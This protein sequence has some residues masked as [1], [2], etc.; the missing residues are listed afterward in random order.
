MR[1]LRKASSLRIFVIASVLG[2]LPVRTSAQDGNL[3]EQLFE[4][5]HS[6]RQGSPQVEGIT[7][8]TKITEDNYQIAEKVLPAEILRVVQAGDM[9]ITVQATSDFPLYEDYIAASLEHFGQAQIGEDGE[10]KN[11]IKGLPFP[12]LDPS[13]PQVGL[14]AA[15]NFRYRYLGSSIQTL[16]TLRS[17]NNSGTVERSVETRYARLYG[18]HR[19]GP[20]SNVPEWEQEGTWWREH[21]I[22]LRP[23]DLEGAQRLTFHHD[24]DTA[25]NGAWVYDPQ[26]RRTRDVVDNHMETSFGLN[27]LVEDHSGFNGYLREHTWRY[28][29][30]QVAL[31]P[32]ILK[33]PQPTLGGKN[34][35]YLTVPW[36]LRKVVIL[37]ATPKNP[38]HPYG[39]R[40]FYIDRQMF[41]VFYAFV[42]DHEGNHWRTLFHCFGDPTFD[43]KNA[44][45]G[46][47][48]HMGNIWVDYKSNHASIWT[49]DEVLISQPL[50]PKMFTVKEMVRRGK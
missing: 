28:M 44:N 2:F 47:P 16:G 17:V 37:E 29:G 46:V 3:K 35:W 50:P 48:L 20:D 12:L 40:R 49:A 6:Y 18:M 1:P 45:V 22:V 10:L 11:Y 34:K 33:G 27:F 23:Q 39:K 41:S 9:E 43:P 26:T 8:G 32:G 30:E 36:E 24:A 7:P 14:K 5:F 25:A 21:S 4:V 13:D 31:V 19:L 38:N 15:W 42:Y